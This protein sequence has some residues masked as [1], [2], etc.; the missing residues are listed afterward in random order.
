[1]VLM[2]PLAAPGK[3]CLEGPYRLTSKGALSSGVGNK[4]QKG[5]PTPG[6]YRANIFEMAG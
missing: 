6:I 5:T 2:R 1:M 4:L 3:Q